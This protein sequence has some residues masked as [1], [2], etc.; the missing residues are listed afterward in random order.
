EDGQYVSRILDVTTRKVRTVPSPIYALTPDGK[1]GL[2]VDFSRL[3]DVRPGYGY[4]GI[5]DPNAG[6]LVTDKTGLYRVE[7]SSGKREMLFSVADIVRRG[8]SLVTM[9]D[10]K[11][12]F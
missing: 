7:L 11:H 10:A 1:T 6:E 9:K 4:I 12:Y 3:N 2:S 5:P 8:P